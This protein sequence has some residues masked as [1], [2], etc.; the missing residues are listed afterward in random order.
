MY[1]RERGNMFWIHLAQVRERWRAV[2][3]MGM[4][5]RVLYRV[6]FI[7]IAVRTSSPTSAGTVSRSS[8]AREPFHY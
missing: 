3:N 5:R 4:N 1:F 7:S 6:I 8:Q 2:V